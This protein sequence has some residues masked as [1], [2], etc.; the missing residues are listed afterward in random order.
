MEREEK[1]EDGKLI[2]TVIEAGVETKKEKKLP[3]DMGGTTVVG[4]R[5]EIT[6]DE[7]F[8][9]AMFE[10]GVLTLNLASCLGFADIAFGQRLMAQIESLLRVVD[11]EYRE[12]RK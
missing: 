4:D 5:I 1:A 12:Q 6:N 11:I 2:E 8:A 7:G 10:R 9:L 3:Q